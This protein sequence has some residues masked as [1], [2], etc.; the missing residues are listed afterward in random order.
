M[1]KYCRYEFEGRVHYGRVEDDTI[2]TLRSEPWYDEIETGDTI[3]IQKVR[4]LAPSE[5]RVI[6]GLGGAYKEAWENKE[7]PVSVRWFVKPP[8][9][10]AAWNDDIIL[11]ASLDEVKA[12]V[13]LVI[14]IGR[15]VKDAG[16]DR[17]VDAIFGY[18]VG[19]DV[20]GTVD[21]YYRRMGE[22]SE[23]NENLLPPA[24]KTCDRFAPFG[25]F[26]YRDIE[27]RNRKRTLK[28]I[29]TNGAQRVLYENSTSGLLYSPGKIV[30]D[31][32]R[33]LTL[34]PGDIIM[35]GTTKSFIAYPGETVEITIEGMGTIKNKI[36]LQEG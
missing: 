18:T 31:I 36:V 24:L 2:Y 22:T 11:P 4:L 5:P 9:S 21:S 28:I 13:E 35:T 17:A 26:I 23:F 29:D 6:I 7:P 33:V 14:V 12:E 20:V 19:N 10:M 32:S 34:S 8:G 3:S 27:W 1:L 30:S 15:K 16:E 25:P